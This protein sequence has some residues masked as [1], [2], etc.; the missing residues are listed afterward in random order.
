MNE[1]SSERGGTTRWMSPELLE[2]SHHT[3]HSDC[4][5]LGMVICEVLSGLLPFHRQQ[6]DPVVAKKVLD[7][8]RPE[9]PQRGEGRWFNDEIW[10][11]LERC[12]KH[13]PSDRPSAQDVFECLDMAS[14]EWESFSPLAMSQQ[15]VDP[16]EGNTSDLSAISMMTIPLYPRMT[17]QSSQ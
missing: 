11:L 16:P 15:G 10:D 14:K 12:W 1:S 13:E 8:E 9:R 5:A 3:V 17:R 7:G 6:G 2:G 4:Y